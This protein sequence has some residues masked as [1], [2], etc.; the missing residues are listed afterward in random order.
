MAMIIESFS[1]LTDTGRVVFTMNENADGFGYG[2]AEGEDTVIS[3]RGESKWDASKSLAVVYAA[4]AW[5]FEVES[6]FV[7]D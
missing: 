3:I 5:E 4:K 7:E 2:S 1:I 6:F